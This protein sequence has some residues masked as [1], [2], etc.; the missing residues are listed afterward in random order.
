[1]EDISRFGVSRAGATF[2]TSSVNTV[3]YTHLPFECENEYL[4]TYIFT[5]YE[6]LYL[7]K[8]LTDFREMTKI[9]RA[10]KDFVEFTNDIFVHEITNNDNGILFFDASKKVLG[11]QNRYEKTKEQYD[12]VYKK[13][14]MQNSD[15]LN[16]VILGLL[17][18]SIVTNIVN[19]I[20]L[21]GTVH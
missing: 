19:F 5:L 20:K 16:N 2:L 10:G 18:I 13:F 11:L 9:K 3:N 12:V 1:M 14:K 17:A 4:Y 7:S 6:K 21:F 15:I 8:L